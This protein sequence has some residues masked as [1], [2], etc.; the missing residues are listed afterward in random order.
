MTYRN[1]EALPERWQ[2]SGVSPGGPIRVVRPSRRAE[3]YS[4]RRVGIGRPSWR[5]GRVLEAIPVGR[6][7]KG[8][9]AEGPI[10][11]ATPSQVT[12]CSR[13]AFPERRHGSGV[14]PGGG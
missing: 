6:W 12:Y 7:G 5:A 14:P 11:V 2:G 9:P 13:E 3:E 1:W 4:G 10:G 8:V